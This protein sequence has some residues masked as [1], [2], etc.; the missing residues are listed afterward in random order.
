[1]SRDAFRPLATTLILTAVL[2]MPQ[3]HRAE[4]TA[5]PDAVAAGHRLAASWC[6]E[7]H[8]IGPGEGTS[9]KGPAFQ[10]IA[11]M[12]SA[13]ELSLKVFLRS[14]HTNMPNVVISPADA[15]DIV[16]YILSLKRN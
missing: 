16:R 7:C 12:P 15:D 14:S 2:L 13:T 9:G 4:A 8:A 1:M 3:P 5:L 11:D 10:H 6:K